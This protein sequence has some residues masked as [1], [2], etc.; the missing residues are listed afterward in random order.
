MI[1][2]K[3]ILLRQ[4]IIINNDNWECTLLNKTKIEQKINL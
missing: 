3:F 4:K 1:K 2:N